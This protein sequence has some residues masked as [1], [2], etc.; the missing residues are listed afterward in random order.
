MTETEIVTE[1]ETV[2]E[3]EIVSETETETD[4]A[5]VLGENFDDETETEIEE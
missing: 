3:K 1:S 4:G 5:C 2:T